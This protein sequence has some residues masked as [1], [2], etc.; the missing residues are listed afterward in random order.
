M[1]NFI[2]ARVFSISINFRRFL[3]LAMLG[4]SGKGCCL[5]ADT[6]FAVDKLRP[7]A[8]PVVVK[9]CAKPTLQMLFEGKF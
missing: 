2:Y 7:C 9:S 1:Q 8:S 5:F 4:D 6:A 3:I